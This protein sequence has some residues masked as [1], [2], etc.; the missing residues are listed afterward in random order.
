MKYIFPLSFKVNNQKLIS[1]LIICVIYFA[2]YI[3]SKYLCS[4]SSVLT[5]VFNVISAL[6]AMYCLMG[7]ITVTNNDINYYTVKA[8]AHYV[9][10]EDVTQSKPKAVKQ[11]NTIKYVFMGLGALLVVAFIVLVLFFIAKK[12]K[13]KKDLY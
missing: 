1:L 3:V 2:I 4:L 5:L 7:I 6:I 10:V 11:N 13:T 12:R 9:P 8:T